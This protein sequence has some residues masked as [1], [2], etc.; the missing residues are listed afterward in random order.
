MVQIQ[1]GR[2]E[3]EATKYRCHCVD[4]PIGQIHLLN[5]RGV[6]RLNTLLRK[7]AEREVWT[8]SGLTPK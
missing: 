6:S 5:H 3:S 2:S 7:R 4:L 1:I 8:R